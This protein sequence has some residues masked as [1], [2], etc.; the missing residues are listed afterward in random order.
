MSVRR[1]RSVG[2]AFL[3]G[4]LMSG[5]IGA[6]AQNGSAQNSTTI[7]DAQIES[8]VLRALASAPQLSSQNIQS[9]TVYGTVTLKG[10]VPAQA[11][12]EN[13]HGVAS[14]R[15]GPFQYGPIATDDG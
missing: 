7:P 3:A 4:G 8:N 14:I 13:D 11:K 6:W 9:S 15:I 10:N 1:F 2:V 5:G 12:T